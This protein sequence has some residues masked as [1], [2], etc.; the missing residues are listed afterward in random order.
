LGLLK[1]STYHKRLGDA[2]RL[3]NGCSSSSWVPDVIYVTSLF[4]YAWRPVHNTVGYYIHEYPTAKII[5]G[6]I[7]A[8]LMPQHAAKS[9]ATIHKGLFRDAEDLLPDYS[10]VPDWNASIIFSSRGCIND[11]PFCAVPKL[12]PEFECK[13][14]IKDLVYRNH[15]KIILWDNNILA[16]PYWKRILLELRGLNL[17]IDFNQGIDTRLMTPEK[18]EVLASLKTYMIRTAFD[19]PEQEGEVEEGIQMLID[20]GVRPRDILVYLLYNFDDTPHDLLHRLQKAIEW[21]VVSY[22]MRYQPVKGR[23]AL[24]KDSFIGR[25]WSPELLEMVADARRVLGSHGAFP[26]HEGLKRKFLKARTLEQA[27]KLRAEGHRK[28]ERQIARAL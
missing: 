8:T 21:G 1:I 20:A 27:L 14:T 4:T 10:L 12:E 19:R 24:E 5:L 25:H 16:S 13:K 22:P 18:A 2:V 23:F 3:Q 15:D 26:P 11:C 9:G 7:Y 6:G 17:Q 28:R